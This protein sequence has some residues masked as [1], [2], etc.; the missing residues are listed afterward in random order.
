MKVWGREDIGAGFALDGDM[1]FE[2]EIW[3]RA[4]GE[5]DGCFG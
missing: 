1:R 5:I 3:D 4:A 2:G